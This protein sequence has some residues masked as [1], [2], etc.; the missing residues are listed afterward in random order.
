MNKT[1]RISVTTASSGDNTLVAAIAGTQVRV[2]NFSLVA[3]TANAVQ[4]KS[5]S[6]ALTGVMSLGATGVLAPGYDPTGHIITAAGEALILNLGS[7]TQVSGWLTYDHG[8]G[9]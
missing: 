8:G 6:T 9:D 7:A 4:F 3:V 2:V 1:N 5:G